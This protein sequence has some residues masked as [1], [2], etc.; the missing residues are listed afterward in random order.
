VSV[1]LACLVVGGVAI[2]SFLPTDKKHLLHTRGR[3]HPLGHLLAFAVVAYAV[4]GVARST[5]T[6]VLFFIGAMVFGF[7]IELAEHLLVNNPLEWDDVWYDAVGV[8]VGT[9]LAIVT[10]PKLPDSAFE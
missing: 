9:L 4:A 3:F 10:A 2:V 8:M 1:A 7:G 5:R 6:R